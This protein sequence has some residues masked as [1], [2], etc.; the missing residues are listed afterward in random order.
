[1]LV[2]RTGDTASAIGAG[3]L[4]KVMSGDRIHTAVSYYYQCSPCDSDNANGL[5]TL[6]TGL[7]NV[8]SNSLGGTAFTKSYA[9]NISTA[10]GNTYEIATFFNP[11]SPS[12]GTT[13]E[14]K[15][16]LHV[17]L[18]D[19]Q[20]KFDDVNSYVEQIEPGDS[21]IRKLGASAVD[22]K[23]NGYA[24]IYFSNE[25]EEFVYFDNFLLTHERS[26]VLEE[27]H[28]YPF[29][30]TMSAIS[31]KAAGVLKNKKGYNSNEI[32]N[33]EFTDGSGLELYDFNART[34]D[35]QIGRFIQIDPETEE[36]GQ[37]AFSPYHFGFNNPISN[38]DPDGKFP[39]PIIGLY[40]AA[41]TAYRIYKGARALDK[42]KD[43]ASRERNA[44]EL[45]KEVVSLLA[46]NSGVVT[47][48]LMEKMI[49]VSADTKEEK[50]R[51]SNNQKTKE[52]AETGQEAH[53]QEQA[54]LKEQAKLNGEEVATEV[55]M[56]LKD[57]TQ[58]RKDAV[59][60]DGTTVII[61]P[62][63]KSGRISAE[64]REKLMQKNGHKT[65]VILYNPKD[66][67]YQPG[68]ATYIGP[69]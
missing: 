63:T 36:G 34:Y 54:K 7:V 51:G 15:A 45:K 44:I 47:G 2:R 9:N 62:D 59:R 49:E 38:S 50:Q 20:F 68:S 37:E 48:Y 31:T 58:V 43:V 46:E 40:R 56:T 26:R 4:L 55:P 57:G 10:I 24:Y 39:T 35:P 32:Q 33:H 8:L 6:T 13:D 69:K 67:K 61:K 64:K 66:P 11:E 14:P 16:Y 42:I 28:Y 53:R 65:E 18:F 60:E 12:G 22:V 21:A 19:E 23:K 29:G 52:A 41:T 1:M 27:T 25:S 5:N 3:K 30:L 17:L